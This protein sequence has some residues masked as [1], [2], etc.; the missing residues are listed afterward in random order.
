MTNLF[1]LSLN[2]WS[3]TKEHQ[4]VFEVLLS[5]LTVALRIGVD[6]GLDSSDLTDWVGDLEGES[7]D[8]VASM[9]S[10]QARK[11]SSLIKSSSSSLV[12]ATS[13]MLRPARPDRRG[14]ELLLKGSPFSVSSRDLTKRTK[15]WSIWL[16]KMVCQ[17]APKSS[18]SNGF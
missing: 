15:K 17:T 18:T 2:F 5:R 11:A 14:P 9:T 8:T 7:E 10:S 4:L 1:N 16:Q 3:S 12:T 13:S 6:L